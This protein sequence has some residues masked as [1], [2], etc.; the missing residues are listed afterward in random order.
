MQRGSNDD[1][2]PARPR[3]R[4]R[5]NPH[6]GNPALG[7]SAGEHRVSARGLSQ[8]D[9]PPRRDARRTAA[10]HRRTG[11]SSM[12]EQAQEQEQQQDTGWEWAIVEVFGHRSHAGRT[13]EEERF[14]AKLLRIDIPNKGKPDEH[15]WT[16]IYYG[17]SSIFS[18]SLATEEAVMKANKPYASPARLSY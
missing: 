15:G 14:G 16:T 6:A 8:R 2:R 11:E 1:H 12:T 3:A 18:F 9:E 13:R 17:G 7:T 4:S 10:T 5:S